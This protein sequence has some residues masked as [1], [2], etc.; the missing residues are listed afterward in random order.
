MVAHPPEIVGRLMGLFRQGLRR[1]QIAESMG[2]TLGVV[3]GIIHRHRHQTFQ[4]PATLL[5]VRSEGDVKKIVKKHP[6]TPLT[7]PIQFSLQSLGLKIVVAGCDKCHVALV[8]ESQG[9][10][11]LCGYCEAAEK[12]PGI[13]LFQD[14]RRRVRGRAA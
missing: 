3:A 2:M 9:A 5:D 7:W 11:Q 12:Q 4:K 8:S 10:R 1:R 6:P 13:P 14:A